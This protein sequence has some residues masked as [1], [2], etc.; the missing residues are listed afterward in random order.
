MTP[1]T[2]TAA[3]KFFFDHAGYSYDPVTETPEQGRIRCARNLAA[4]EALAREAGVSFAWE[5][6][7]DIDSSDFDDSTD[8]WALWTCVAYD[9]TG[10]VAASLGGVDFGRDGT[11]HGDDY[12]R[13][14][15]AELA[16]ECID[17]TLATAATSTPRA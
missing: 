14:V 2:L 4:A 11:P 12:R 10:A 16:D 1:H 5:V 6:D 15:E 3:E 8:P 17:R 13:V 7:Q 9:C